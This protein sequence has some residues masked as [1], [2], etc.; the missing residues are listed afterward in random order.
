MMRAANSRVLDLAQACLEWQRNYEP[1][2]RALVETRTEQLG[3]DDFERHNAFRSIDALAWKMTAA[4]VHLERLWEHRE[5]SS[6]ARLIETFLTNESDPRRFTEVKT[7]LLAAEF[8]AFV[9]QARAFIT[10]AQVHTLD[11]CRV[12]F[13]GQ[14]T[15]KKYRRLVRGAE[16]D[17]RERLR[18]AH[19]YFERAV[20]GRDNW[21]ALVKSLRDR[22][23]HFDRIRPSRSVSS[24]EP[25]R[26]TLTGLTLER[27]AQDFENGTY[28]LL[29]RVIAPVWEREWEPG[30]YQPRMWT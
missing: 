21:G 28:N 29:V 11:A 30:P 10:V 9:V 14:L 2:L 15:R 24:D 6:V 5:S 13:G 4:G 25:G 16:E 19:N 20:F 3:F 7:T 8:E 27:L 17:V 12:K 22:A 23:L 18:K 1:K 26:L